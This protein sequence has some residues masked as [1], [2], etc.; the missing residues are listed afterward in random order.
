MTLL[1][2]G[3]E[4]GRSRFSAVVASILGIFLFVTAQ[5]VKA[6]PP[7]PPIPDCV[8]IPVGIGCYAELT[9]LCSATEGAL[10]GVN[11]AA[12][13]EGFKDQRDRDTLVSKVV[14]AG[15]KI[16][17]GKVSSAG[18]EDPEEKLLQYGAKLDSLPAPPDPKAKI[19]DTLKTNLNALLLVAEGCVMG[20]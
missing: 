20:L 13:D 14:G 9:A 15:V 10:V 16:S 4:M 8:N 1:I 17:Q 18:F 3:R 5:A 12:G 11:I 19:S 6:Q 2:E 7:G